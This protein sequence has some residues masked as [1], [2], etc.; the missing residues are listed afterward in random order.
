MTVGALAGHLLAVVRTPERRCDTGIDATAT[1]VEP[2]AGYA[3]LRLDRALDLDDP[4]FRTVRKGAA[5]LAQR[6]APE[7]TERFTA[8]V[9]RLVARLRAAPPVRIQLPEPTQC[10]TL[11]AYLIKRIVE[12]VVHT[13]DLALSTGT[14]TDPPD[15]SVATLVIDFLVAAD[16][17][18]IGDARVMR[19]LAGRTDP[20]DLRAL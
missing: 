1:L 11:E 19:A 4:R 20:D 18:R 13:D 17:Q 8:C 6:G 3:Q 16:R 15:S 7:V 10:T 9:A 12:L 2:A 5:R 14:S